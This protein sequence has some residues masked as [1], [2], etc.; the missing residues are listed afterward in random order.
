MPQLGATIA[1]R[2]VTDGESREIMRDLVRAMTQTI[3]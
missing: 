3:D 2:P 1:G